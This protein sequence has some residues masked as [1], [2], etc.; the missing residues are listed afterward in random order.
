M[1]RQFNLKTH[2]FADPVIV[3]DEAGQPILT[4]PPASEIGQLQ[5][6]TSGD[7]WIALYNQ[8]EIDAIS[9]SITSGGT[10]WL[11]G[12][13]LHTSGKPPSLYHYWNGKEWELSKERQQAV[14][15]AEKSAKL[16]EIN[17]KAQAF[18]NQLAHLDETPEFERETWAIQREEAKAWFMDNA[19]ETPTLAMI[20][21]VRGV[22]LD[23]LRRKAYEKAIAYQTVA[24][25]VA[26]QR[27]AY[28]DRL[29]RAE[30]LEQIQA[31]EPVYQLPQQ[32]EKKDA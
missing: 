19:A 31:I 16:A 32:G 7:D 14:I 3:T 23:I 28:E 5:Y 24:A 9:S 2:I 17:A 8:S 22:P 26:G 30:T 12:G 4:T 10:V 6:T 29:N 11:E 27:Q 20:A 18:V 15:S 21:Q 13:K 25:V 1:I